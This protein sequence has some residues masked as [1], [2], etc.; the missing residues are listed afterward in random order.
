MFTGVVGAL[1]Q[2]AVRTDQLINQSAPHSAPIYLTWT[3]DRKINGRYCIWQVLKFQSWPAL[4]KTATC[5][6]HLVIFSNPL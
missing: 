5:T 4:W 3:A 2:H 1:M 6:L